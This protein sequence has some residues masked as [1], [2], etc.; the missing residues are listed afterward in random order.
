MHKCGYFRSHQEITQ[1][2][3]K[4]YV[5]AKGD[6]QPSPMIC[7]VDVV[8]IT[9]DETA[10]YWCS[11]NRRN[12]RIERGN[13][14]AQA[15]RMCLSIMGCSFNYLPDAIAIN[16]GRTNGLDYSVGSHLLLSRPVDEI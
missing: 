5:Q 2:N 10:A 14:T 1:A 8:P 3:A 13:I 9:E 11:Q 6:G 16:L 12:A 4:V 15:I 7:L